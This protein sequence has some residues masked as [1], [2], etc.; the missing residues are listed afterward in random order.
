VT[1]EKAAAPHV[2]VVVPVRDE[3]ENIGPLLDRLTAVGA[4]AGKCEI[5]VVDD[6]SVD[7]TP[8]EVSR[9]ARLASAEGHEVRPVALSTDLAPGGTR[10]EI[11]NERRLKS[12]CSTKPGRCQ[13][14]NKRKGS[15]PP[16]IPSHRWPPASATHV[17]M[18]P[19]VTLYNNTHTGKAVFV[20]TKPTRQNTKG[21]MRHDSPRLDGDH[22]FFGEA[23][24]GKTIRRTTTG[25]CVCQGCRPGEHL[26]MGQQ[27]CCFPAGEAGSYPA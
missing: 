1:G 14:S 19:T 8:A 5:L 6:H 25:A 10:L 9:V 21:R 24:Y 2:S 22:R 18:G 20:A 12:L 27:F 23:N 15:R 26:T 16:A 7:G 3:R 4:L 17:T 13:D 11:L